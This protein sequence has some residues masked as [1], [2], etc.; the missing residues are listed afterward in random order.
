VQADVAV[1]YLGINEKFLINL[2]GG[3][4]VQIQRTQTTN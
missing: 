1:Q 4:S 2:Q 3:V